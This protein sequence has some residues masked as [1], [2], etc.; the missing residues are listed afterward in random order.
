MAPD[1]LLAGRV[2]MVSGSAG[3]IGRVVV[4]ALSAAGA[5]VSLCDFRVPDEADH[6]ATTTGDLTDPDVAAA[7]AGHTIDRFGHVDAL[8]NVA[9]LWRSQSFIDITPDVY[10]T[11]LDANLTTTWNACHAA[12]PHLLDRGTG[13]IVNF[14]S[15]A[16]QGGSIRPGSHYA[17]AKGAIIALTK[18]LARELSPLGVRVNAISP[19]PVDTGA[20]GSG[21]DFDDE[22]VRNRTLLRRVGRPEEIA[23]GVLYLVSDASSFATGSVLAVN[24][25][26][27]L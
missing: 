26:S 17:A 20:A 7:W 19:G 13:S 8:V 15:T 11:I 2:V 12:V 14:A 4:E 25:G 24:G 10:R 1:D 22:E 16:G 5:A 18:S 9:G 3:G 23:D 6:L 27:L 21:V